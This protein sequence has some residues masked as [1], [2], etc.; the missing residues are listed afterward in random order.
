MSITS[1]FKQQ[2]EIARVLGIPVRI[3]YRWFFVFVLMMWLTAS[4]I[5]KEFGL[6]PLAALF[7]GALTTAAF[8]LS[9][10]GHELAHA[11]AARFEGIDTREIVLHPFGGL[12]RLAHEPETPRAEF[13]I[14]VA[15]PAASFLFGILFLVATLISDQAGAGTA[16]ALFFLLFFGNVLLAIFNLFP[17]YPLDGGRVLRAFLWKQGYDLNEATRM[18]G[19]CGQLI[20][21]ALIG[22]GLFVTVW[23]G[24]L[25][26]GI[27]TVLTGVFLL[28][29]AVG[30][31]GHTLK[32]EKIT[33][34][35]VMTPPV[36]VKPEATVSQFVD[37]TLPLHRQ[38]A[39]PVALDKRLHGILTLEDLKKLPRTVWHKT[40]VRDVMRPINED[41]FVSPAVRLSD[42]R[43]LMNENGAG[44]LAVVDDRG[45]LIGFLQRGNKVRQKV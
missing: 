1:F 4:N 18:T 34:G 36:A 8:F 35:E 38:A 42:A 28:D 17:G 13:R 41:L 20:A 7:L 22:F 24:D 32:A 29:S 26:T 19:R 14:A 31:V 12:A 15:G 27:W 16:A 2:I 11:L 9:I 21:I 23:R 33:V 43:E 10:F 30:I 45:L 25:F 44:A 5:P 37:H 39:F 6:D 3:D 40:V